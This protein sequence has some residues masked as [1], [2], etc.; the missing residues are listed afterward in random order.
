MVKVL[1]TIFVENHRAATELALS[2]RVESVFVDDRQMLQLKG[3]PL[4]EVTSAT[5]KYAVWY[6]RIGNSI[7]LH[8]YFVMSQRSSD[9]A[10]A[11]VVHQIC[12]RHVGTVF[13]RQEERRAGHL[14]G[15]A[16]STERN[17]THIH[18]HQRI[19]ASQS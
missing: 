16:E 5:F 3:L 15:G 8:R 7:V 6:V 10:N 12:T 19:A 2:P 9:L 4:G 11:T 18:F 13:G 17:H 14:L 1:L